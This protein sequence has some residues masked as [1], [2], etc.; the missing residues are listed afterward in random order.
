MKQE[1]EKMDKG[2]GTREWGQGNGDKGIDSR[3]FLDQHSMV[4]ICIVVPRMLSH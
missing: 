2:M 1:T 4:I 3:V